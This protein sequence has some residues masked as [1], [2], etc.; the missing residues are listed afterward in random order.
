MSEAPA[1]GID[2][3]TTNSVVA[4]ARAHG[5]EVLRDEAGSALVPSVVSFHPSG[6]VLVGA[7]ARDRRMLDARNTIYSVKRLL[8]RPFA[9]T[10]VQRA[11]ERFPFQLIEGPSGSVLVEVRGE[12]Y[13]LSEVSALLL[14]ELRGF[15]SKRLGGQVQRAVVTVPANFNELQ[16]SAT[17]AAARVAGLEVLRILNE[18]TAAAL[19]YGYGRSGARERIAVF[20]L[21]GGTFD[22]T[23]LELAGEV[24]EVVA[25]AGDTYLGGDDV[26]ALVAERMAEVFLEQ[27]RYDPRADAQAIE[28]LRVAA[29]WLK[30]QLSERPEALV[31][32]EE[33][34]YGPDGVP[35][36]LEFRMARTELERMA[37]PLLAR[38]FD[39]CEDA[40]RVAG[41]RPT[42]LD[43]VVLVGGSTRMPLVRRMVQDYFGSEPLAHIDPD[44]VVAQGAAI[45]ARALDVRRSA[46]GGRKALGRITL[47]R[48]AAVPKDAPPPAAP[49]GGVVEEVATGIHPG[50]AP[51]PGEVRGR[52]DRW[53]ESPPLRP[54]PAPPVPPPPP[55]EAVPS[56]PARQLP[57]QPPPLPQASAAAILGG[58]APA[59]Q[60]PD[61][62]LELD[63]GQVELLEEAVAPPDVPLLLDVTPLTLSLETV[64]GYCEPVI[65]RNSAIPASETKVFT[66]AAD[67]QT[68]VRVRISQGESRRIEENQLL[69][70]IELAGLP[71][72][73]RGKVQVD[74]T[75]VIGADG[76]LDVQA[77]DRATGQQRAVRVDLLGG[78]SDEAEIE[79][80]RARHEHIHVRGES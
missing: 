80:M 12:R 31:R 35:L 30:C 54:A 6:E 47:R 70:E 33:L 40:M 44:L 69:G 42:Q 72:M 14:R 10:E 77:R 75:F 17:K 13:A 15:A 34:A 59:Q 20:D 11:R 78:L 55:P 73:A 4:V 36:D 79:R 32:V 56:E 65:P 25:T 8:G 27:H 57:P 16:R 48:V 29:E 66:T 1:I 63:D 2:L 22:L 67:G 68:E 74:V 3:G 61:E 62:P 46:S 50:S 53:S 45:Q 71:P 60:P 52:E 19:A 5:V 18:P 24:F 28:R 26:D 76:T 51:A 58:G 7:P 38:A 49:L 21:G 39:V 37:Q 41:L 9:S 23:I 64:G 43:N